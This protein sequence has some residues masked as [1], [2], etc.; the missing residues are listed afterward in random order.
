MFQP[1]LH[2]TFSLISIFSLTIF[3]Y[4]FGQYTFAMKRLFAVIFIVSVC[5]LMS[6]HGY[7]FSYKFY[8]SSVQK[9]KG[10]H[11]SHSSC[12]NNN[13]IELGYQFSR[14]HCTGNKLKN[15]SCSL[16]SSYTTFNYNLFYPLAGIKNSHTFFIAA[17]RLLIFPFHDFW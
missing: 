11:F 3:E 13:E 14:P 6:E 8:N 10:S 5:F 7:A 1:L 12:A 15:L 4:I 2:F 16:P 9:K 17:S